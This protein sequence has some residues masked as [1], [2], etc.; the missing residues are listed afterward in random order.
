MMPLDSADAR[1]LRSSLALL[2]S[3]KD[4]E[5]LAALNAVGRLLDKG[6]LSYADLA[7]AEPKAL[8]RA[9]FPDRGGPPEPVRP[10]RNHQRAAWL[11]LSSS[12]PWDAW[13]RGFLSDIRHLVS[14]LSPKQE[15]KLREFRRLADEWRAAA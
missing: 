9:M 2:A 7:P 13:Q 12:Y 6:G 14:P 4:G 11:L 1:R 15:A 10:M 3:D 8:R 5:R